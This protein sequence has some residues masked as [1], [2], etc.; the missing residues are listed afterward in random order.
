MVLDD[1]EQKREK[2]NRNSI[3][4]EKSMNIT[5]RKETKRVYVI[6]GVR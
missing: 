6:Q 4:Q 2:K 3:G 1:T 5:E